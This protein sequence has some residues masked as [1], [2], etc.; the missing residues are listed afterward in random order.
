MRNKIIAVLA[1]AALMFTA[2]DDTTDNVGISLTNSL[3]NLQI[4]TDTFMV[5]TRS[6][7]ADSVLSRNTLGYLGKIRDP[8]TGGY[9]TGNFMTQ[10]HIQENYQF[11]DADKM[12]NKEDGM[13]VADSCEIRLYYD[14]F[15]GDS[16]A[17][18][19]LTAYEMSRP[20]SEANTY[21]SNFD[22]IENGYVGTNGLQADK[23]YTLTDQQINEKTRWAKD[24]RTTV[25]IS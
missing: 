1:F 11:P 21:Y 17:P 2:C 9:I 24:I 5:S 8:E 14:K 19:K 7:A 6:I 13:I 4:S 25:P 10:F 22:P 20:M 23:V 18:M 15:Y 3:D 16:L 12:V